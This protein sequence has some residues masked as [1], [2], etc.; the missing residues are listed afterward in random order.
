MLGRIEKLP[1]LRQIEMFG[2]LGKWQEYF[3]YDYLEIENHQEEI[4]EMEKARFVGTECYG[5]FLYRDDGKI[6]LEMNKGYTEEEELE[7]SPKNYYNSPQ[8][9]RILM[10]SVPDAVLNEWKRLLE[11]IK[12]KLM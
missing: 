7:L 6:W 12:E 5:I 10:V 2:K 1:T 11:S 8:N 4:E 9:Y 3:Y